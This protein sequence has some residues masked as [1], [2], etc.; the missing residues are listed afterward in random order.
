MTKL[1]ILFFI[2]FNFCTYSQEKKCSDFRTGTFIYSNPLYKNW[3]VV[4]SDNEQIEIDDVEKIKL[5]ASVDWIS[6]CEYN[7]T[8]TK[9]NDSDDSP[10]IGKK[11][12]V[13]IIKVG[14]NSV[15]CKSEGLSAILE[16][17]MLLNQ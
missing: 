1:T 10:I 5:Q 3:K 11:I 15:V 17:E 7:L 8:Y 6:D 4:R 13:K 12:N 14:K 16:L 9:F 2:A